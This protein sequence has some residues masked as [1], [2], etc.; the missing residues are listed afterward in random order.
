MNMDVSNDELKEL[1]DKFL[2]RLDNMDKDRDKMIEKLKSLSSA[3]KNVNADLDDIF[4]QLG[5]DMSLSFET[6]EDGFDEEDIKKLSV[7]IDSNKDKFSDDEYLS[8]ISSIVG[9]A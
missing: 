9:E 8:L 4:H 6:N 7:L 3:V 5:G 2:K 1:L